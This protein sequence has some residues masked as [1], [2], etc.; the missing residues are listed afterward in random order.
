MTFAPTQ[1]AG[2]LFGLITT[3]WIGTI[4]LAIP[5]AQDGA[6]RAA[7]APAGA[8]PAGQAPPPGAG[9]AGFGRGPSPGAALYTEHC[10]SCHG[11]DLS[12]GRAPSLFDEKWLLTAT[13]DHI[14]TTV[15]NGVPAAGMD[16]F[17]DR[18]NEAQVWQ[19]IQYIRTQSGALRTRP[20]FV[21]EPHNAIVKTE[22]QTVRLE[23]VAK[24]LNTPWGIA[25]LPDGR[26]LVTERTVN[27][28]QL[29]VIDKGVLQPP[30]TGTP[31]VHVQQDAGMFDVQVHP[32]YAENGWIYLSYA[33][34]VPGYAPPPPAPP[35]ADGVAPGRGRGPAAGPSM[36]TIIR[37]KLRNNEWVEQQVIYRAPAELFTTSGIHYGSRFIFDTQGHLFYSLGDRGVMENAQNLSSPLGKIHRVNDDGTIPRDN[38]FV[39]TPNALGSI[40]SYGHRNPQGF[41]WDPVTG[42][43]WESEHGPTAGDEIN[44]IE[45]GHNY[46]W[47]VATKGTQPGIT[48]TS[49]PGMDEPKAYYIPTY[50][51]AGISFYTGDKY[52]AWR[53]TSLFVGGLAGQALRRL[54]IAGDKVTRQ[55]VLFNQYG[56]VRDVV[57][58]PDGYFYLAINNATGAGTN[59]G[60]VAP[61]PGWIV[62]MVPAQ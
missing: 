53:N 7:G 6:G 26:M 44:L 55:E 1:R 34:T 17:K 52:P 3:L 51:P 61:V 19:L 35:P 4:A 56:R 36:T 46:G 30:V 50:A 15:R 43:L 48:K 49:E 42:K 20:T 8:P 25:F 2:A 29:R 62:R 41:A 18:L 60:L 54:E 5:S 57:Q 10:A 32:R 16:S 38:P 21:P 27:G 40:W 11:T 22:K 13:D 37:G 58:G 23:V 59:Y 31:K 14:A 33:E 45:R 12:G 28:G 39:N 24:D 47:G 9:R